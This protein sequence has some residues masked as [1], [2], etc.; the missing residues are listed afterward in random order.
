MQD[1]ALG[2]TGMTVG[3]IAGIKITKPHNHEKT[4]H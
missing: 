2:I 3:I 4:S 1:I